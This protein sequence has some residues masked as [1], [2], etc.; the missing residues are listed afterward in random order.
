MAVIRKISGGSQSN[1]GAA[2]HAVLMSVVQTISL[3]KQN[4]L[5]TFPKLLAL[6][7]QSYAVALGKGE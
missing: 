2:T 4:I 5:D 3:K 7:G 6:P 1:Q